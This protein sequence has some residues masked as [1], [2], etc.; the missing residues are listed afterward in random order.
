MFMKP[1]EDKLPDLT[2]DDLDR[3]AAHWDVIRDRLRTTLE[4]WN[5]ET[6]LESRT[7]KMPGSGTITLPAM[8][9]LADYPFLDEKAFK[10]FCL[11]LTSQC[12]LIT[13]RLYESENKAD[14]GEYNPEF[15]TTLSV[16]IVEFFEGVLKAMFL[17]K[18][19]ETDVLRLVKLCVQCAYIEQ[20]SGTFLEGNFTPTIKNILLDKFQSGE[21][22]LPFDLNV[23][24]ESRGPS[25]NWEW[26]RHPVFSGRFKR[27]IDEQTFHEYFAD[28]ARKLGYKITDFAT[29]TSDSSN[30]EVAAT[31][32]NIRTNIAEAEPFGPSRE[33]DS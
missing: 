33:N 24:K 21:S 10:S 4:Y 3:M 5:I 1:T 8:D 20:G 7:F 28:I 32:N 18:L 13:R 2:P 9:R 29:P 25:A 26:Q 27:R 31:A 17:P 19:N 15:E 12:L 23:M 22:D 14:G 11:F 16:A 6:I 30:G